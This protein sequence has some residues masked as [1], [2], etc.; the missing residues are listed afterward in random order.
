MVVALC[1]GIVVLASVKHV[2]V[3]LRASVAVAVLVAS[4]LVDVAVVAASALLM[5]ATLP[6]ACPAG[7]AENVVAAS[8]AEFNYAPT[9]LT[10]LNALP[11]EILQ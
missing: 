7:C 5:N 8:A 3:A 10:K 4:A 2:V 11:L 1:L 6:A 9:M